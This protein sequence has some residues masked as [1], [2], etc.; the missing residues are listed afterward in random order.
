MKNIT[1]SIDDALYER[2][3]V[4]A[5]Q[6]KSSVSGLVRAYLQSLSDVEQRREQAG[7]KG[8]LSECGVERDRLPQL[9]AEAAKQWTGTFNPRELTQA[10]WLQLYEQ[11]F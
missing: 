5:A 10:D 1:L 8:R 6:R 11:A 9:A 4:L 7:L 2:S 3:R